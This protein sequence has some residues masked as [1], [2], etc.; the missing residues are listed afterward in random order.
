LKTQPA[1]TE[2]VPSLMVF[3]RRIW[4]YVRRERGRLA[5]GATALLLASAMRLLEP[6]PLKFVFDRVFQVGKQPRSAFLAGWS[7]G[8]LLIAC[9]VAVL[10]FSGLRA[11]LE[12][13]QTTSFA[14]A[15]NRVLANV[16]G[17]VFRHLQ[18]LS[19]RFHNTARTGDLVVRVIGD[20]NMLKDVAVTA[21]VPMVANSLILAGMIALML[22]LEWQLALIVLATMPLFWVFSM[23]VGRKIKDVA[24][25]QRQ[26]EGAMAATASEAMGAIKTVQALS[27]EPAFEGA[28][29]ASNTKSQKADARGS[30]LSATL[31]RGVDGLIAVATAVVLLVGGRAVID[32]RMTGGDL[33]V[34]LTYLR[35]VFNPLQDF[36]KYSGRLAKASAAGGRILDI[37]DREPD[38]Q[39]APDARTITITE[40][41]VAL[42]SVTFGYEPGHPVLKGVSLS[43]G[44]GETVAVVGESGV[45][46]STIMSLL[47]RLYDPDSGS[48]RIGGHDAREFTVASL[49]SQVAVVLQDTLLFSGTVYENIAFGSPDATAEEVESAARLANA[50]GFISRMPNGYGTKVGERGMTLSNGQRQRIA[51]ARAALRNAPILILDEPL[52]GLDEENQREVWAALQRLSEGRTTLLVTHDLNQAQQCDRIL[53]LGEGKI[54]EAGTHVELIAQRG[55]YA[56]LRGSNGGAYAVGC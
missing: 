27:L 17:E 19:L 2:A 42:E 34:F 49:R 55:A 41:T 33:L 15:G 26:R 45:G 11:L 53:L 12:Y 51:I 5:F 29:G 8:N 37:L 16:R 43:V 52:T 1:L 32:G 20:V 7:T 21:M 35:R 23:R 14:I 44:R 48:V 38:I 22:W 54:A 56:R 6:W 40:P 24:R 13:F 10:V 9:A 50:H 30:R 18:C 31:E 3:Y 46:K 25:Q 39:D 47:L 28:F 36:A 4:P